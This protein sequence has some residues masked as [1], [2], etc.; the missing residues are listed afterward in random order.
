[1]YRILCPVHDT[2]YSMYIPEHVACMEHRKC[3][4]ISKMLGPRHESMWHVASYEAQEI[5]WGIYLGSL[6]F[7][8]LEIVHSLYQPVAGYVYKMCEFQ[9]I[10][11]QP[12]YQQYMYQSSKFISTFFQ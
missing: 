1:M 7:H 6:K 11:T 12:K 3:I 10:S 5:L 4:G 2:S 8:A 9:D